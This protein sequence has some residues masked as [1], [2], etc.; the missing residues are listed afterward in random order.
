MHTRFLIAVAFLIA[1]ALPARA[2]DTPPTAPVVEFKTTPVWVPV[3]GTDKKVLMIQADQRPKYDIFSFNNRY[4][5]HKGDYWF[6]SD[7]L[8][9]PYAVVE[10]NAVP[11]EFKNVPKESWVVYPTNW[12]SMGTSSGP[13]SVYGG[14][15]GPG[16]TGS[17][18]TVAGGTTS[19]TTGTIVGKTSDAE[20]VWVPTISFETAPKWTTVPGSAQVYYV[21]KT[22]RP[23]TYDLYRYN[24]TYYT[25]QKDN[26]YSATTLNG[27]YTVVATDDVPLAFR[28]V[29]KTYWVT[30]P[31]GW[32]YLTPGQVTT[33]MKAKT[34]VKTEADGTVKTETKTETKG[35]K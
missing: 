20:D 26:W 34:K 21:D 2:S 32:T 10:A 25:Y 22:A 6:S 35:T 13:G 16:M 23:T 8:N 33:Q 4:Y 19:A 12:G 15:S 11:T 18:S 17:T 14:S 27:P 1:A 24:N 30:Y 7:V 3:E 9:G 31:T 5:V 29:K 28:S